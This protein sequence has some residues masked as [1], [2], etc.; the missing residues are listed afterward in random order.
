MSTSD[1]SLSEWTC[2]FWE[3]SKFATRFRFAYI[4]TVFI[5]YVFKGKE[6]NGQS[7]N[8]QFKRLS[9]RD[10]DNARNWSY[11]R[12]TLERDKSMEFEPC[13]ERQKQKKGDAWCIVAT[14]SQVAVEPWGCVNTC[15]GISRERWWSCIMAT[16][17]SLLS[18]YIKILHH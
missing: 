15:S 17:N 12:P 1:A 13:E 5:I 6:A 8:Y 14:L 4:Q 10:A 7:K 9:S 18:H 11:Q 2:Y 3:W 16:Q